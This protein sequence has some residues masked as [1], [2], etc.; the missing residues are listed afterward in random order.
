MILRTILL[1]LFCLGMT[2]PVRADEPAGITPDMALPAPDAQALIPLPK[3]IRAVSERFLG[4]PLAT[5]LRPPLAGETAL[6]AALV[7]ELRWLTPGDDILR[8]RIDAVTGRFLETAGPGL[9]EARRK[10]KP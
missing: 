8:I 3:V 9:T 1:C 7:Y 6:G 10:E 5:A 4:R 2:G